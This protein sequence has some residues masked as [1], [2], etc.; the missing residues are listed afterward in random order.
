MNQLTS[1]SGAL[2]INKPKGRTSFSLVSALRKACNV[3]KIG[4]AGTLDP[5]ASGVM[6]LLVGREFTRLSDKFLL[7]NKEYEATLHFGIKTDSYDCDGQI[8]QNSSHVPSLDEVSQ[9]LETFQG[10]QLQI[11]PMFSAKKVN[12]K[13]L[14]ELARK[15]IEIER[16]PVP[17]SVQIQFITYEYPFLKIHV[18]CSNG[19][20]IRSLANDIGEAL[21]CGAHLSDL[22]RTK[23]GPF[24]LVDC[25][26][27]ERLAT[28]GILSSL[29][30]LSASDLPIDNI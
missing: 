3:K 18:A 30:F 7:Q 12:G 14:Y 16:A 15:G 2:L 21:T 13:K 20:Y 4:H 17:V 26:D 5:F 8:L 24:K 9:V 29:P 10:D 28:P 19:T 11:P 27:G 6:V 23:S 1:P 22:V 25:F